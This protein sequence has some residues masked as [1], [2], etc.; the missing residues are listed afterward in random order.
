[1]NV[2]EDQGSK[3]AKE[4]SGV[5]VTKEESV[6][7][8]MA[9]DQPIPPQELKEKVEAFKEQREADDK[10]NLKEMGQHPRCILLSSPEMLDLS[11][12][13]PGSDKTNTR[14]DFALVRD[15]VGIKGLLNADF[16][17]GYG[18]KALEHTEF[19][20]LVKLAYKNGFDAMRNTASPDGE[21]LVFWYY[22]GHGLGKDKARNL[23]YSSTPHLEDDYKAVNHLVEEGGKVKGGELFLHKFGFCGL[24][25]LL[26]PWIA[27][28]KLESINAK[29]AKKKNKH[30]V[31]ILDS[32]HSGIL[33][34]DLQEFKD[35]VQAED[36]SL[37][38]GNSITIQAACGPNERTFGGY[39]TPCFTYLNQDENSSWLQG[40]KEEWDKMTTQEKNEYESI[41]LP[42]P[43]VVSTRGQSQEP[44]MEVAAQN[45]KLELF[46]HPGFFKFCSIKFCQLEDKQFL[47]EQNDRALNDSSAKAFMQS[48]KFTVLD[49]KLKTVTAADPSYKYGGTPLGLFLLEDPH[50]AQLAI[51]AHIHFIDRNTAKAPSRIN[52]VHHR[53]Q[54]KRA[55]V[56]FY[57]EKLPKREI[58]VDGSQ[59]LVEACRAYV[60]K[61]SCQGTWADVSKWNM[62]KSFNNSF[63]LQE[64]SA[65]EDDYL[66]YITNFDLPKVQLQP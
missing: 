8:T 23:T 43:V 46:P 35:H 2:G 40:L 25:G 1:M 7:N 32:C 18:E 57:T 26:K 66:E 4:E 36:P 64:R 33:A 39:F 16:Y 42:S 28:V 31:I 47:P 49:Y 21:E 27:A 11:M 38:E 15:W 61:N 3:I 53:K 29:G 17:Q 37:L 54:L 52:L 24:H 19:G 14:E 55:G 44:T 9:V 48:Q 45:L 51:C 5:E 59:V 13:Y 58:R 65:W 22:T 63:K 10:A 50:N 30:L 34:N 12:N 56:F 41:D 62:K 6:D 60:T 20:A